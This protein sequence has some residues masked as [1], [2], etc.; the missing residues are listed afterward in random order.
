MFNLVKLQ[1]TFISIC[2]VRLHN[3]PSYDF[4]NFEGDL[5]MNSDQFKP[6]LFIV[7]NSDAPE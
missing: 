3:K 2:G 4:Q 5:N 7:N 1:S 6:S